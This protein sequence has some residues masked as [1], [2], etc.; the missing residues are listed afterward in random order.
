MAERTLVVSATNL[1]A[2]GFM[3]VPTDRTDPEG[4]VVNALFSVARAIVR[5]VAFKLP[6]RAVAVIDPTPRPTWPVILAAQL[7]RLGELCRT[8]GLAVVETGV[9]VRREQ[10]RALHPGDGREAVRCGTRTSR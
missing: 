7:P 6:A 3:V 10:G 9:V 1:L 4:L 8:L 5:G 2:R